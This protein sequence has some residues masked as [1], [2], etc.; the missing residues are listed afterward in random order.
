MMIHMPAVIKSVLE[1]GLLIKAATTTTQ[2]GHCLC[3][4]HGE[5]EAQI[6]TCKQLRSE[7]LKEQKLGR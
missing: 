3:S 1:V 7:Y 6:G 5:D 4:L 2:Q